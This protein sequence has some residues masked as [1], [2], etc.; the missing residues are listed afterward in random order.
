[1]A[2]T[3]MT[4]LVIVSTTVSLTTFIALSCYINTFSVKQTSK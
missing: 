2:L 4:D 1:M 3:H